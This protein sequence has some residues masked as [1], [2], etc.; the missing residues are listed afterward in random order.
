M[1]LLCQDG[2]KTSS[3]KGCKRQQMEIYIQSAGCRTPSSSAVPRARFHS[4][5]VSSDDARSF[6]D[7]SE[8][9]LPQPDRAPEQRT[10]PLLSAFNFY[11]S[12]LIS[13]LGSPR[14]PAPA[15]CCEALPAYAGRL[16]GES[17]TRPFPRSC[18]ATVGL[19]KRQ[20]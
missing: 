10:F 18:L 4:G 6:F 17:L 19:E 16:H 13:I 20:I 1:K 7:T 15:S 2:L 11:L 14:P 8:E 3:E 9:T 5:N 12:I